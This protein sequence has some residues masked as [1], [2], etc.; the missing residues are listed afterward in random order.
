MRH[1]RDATP[2]V[3]RVR[4][5][6]R[7]RSS[8]R[9]APPSH[10]DIAG[11]LPVEATVSGVNTR[12]DWCRGRRAESIAGSTSR[13]AAA[14]AA[15]FAAALLGWLVAGRAEAA[16]QAG[17]AA[18]VRG[19]VLLDRESAI[20]AKL[21]SGEKI[22]LGDRLTTSADS[23]L[24]VMLLDETVFT[25]GPNS[26]MVIDKFVYD[27]ATGDGTLDTEL[28]RGAFRFVSGRIAKR[29]PES[30][31]VRLPAGTIGIR[32]TMVHTSVD[33]V[34][35]RSLVVL[36]G[37]GEQNTAGIAAGAIQVANGGVSRDVVRSGWGVEI[38]GF[39][40]PPSEPFLVPAELYQD[41]SFDAAAGQGGGGGG[42]GDGEGDGDGQGSP[43]GQGQSGGST[44]GSS[45][46]STSSSSGSTSSSSTTSGTGSTG[47]STLGAG[48][49]AG[50]SIVTGTTGGALQTSVDAGTVDLENL[51][52]DVVQEMS[53]D[54]AGTLDE[55]G[56]DLTTLMDL[57]SLAQMQTPPFAYDFVA[58]GLT[59][60]DGSFDLS[61]ALDFGSMQVFADLF[62]VSSSSLGTTGSGFGSGSVPF[63]AGVFENGTQLATFQIA[64][65][66]MES[67]GV[68]A[69]SCPVNLTLEF[70]DT[71]TQIAGQVF[72]MG[73]IRNQA[74]TIIVQ[75]A[76]ATVPFFIGESLGGP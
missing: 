66:Y 28:V 43:S 70:Q 69:Q 33:P 76:P 12:I 71:P 53:M 73:S 55:M 75:I 60:G 58:A 49:V 51:G 74:Q 56:L 24:Q 46:G 39:G 32:G 9:F 35:G 14:V 42:D 15:A 50:E 36:T 17:V 61:V 57:T 5:A 7:V 25:L 8:L 6:R 3:V 1:A 31:R 19:R 10:L 20:G 40:A 54:M 44:A 59:N 52:Q 63:S 18:A 64:L 30:M 13:H 62:S 2:P 45:T 23:G 38:Q 65:S 22:F 16:P 4:V 27:P 11:W 21:A 26:S 37:P 34:T 67:V 72:V 48:D 47:S 29:S 68:C 41:A